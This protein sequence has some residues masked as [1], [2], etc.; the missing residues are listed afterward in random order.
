MSVRM[1][2]SNS[3]T[4]PDRAAFAPARR[5]L[6]LGLGLLL[7][8]AGLA[9]GFWLARGRTPAV[10]PDSP[11]VG[12]ARD[13]ASHHAQAVEMAVVLREN[14]DDPKM[15][16]LALDIMLTQQGQIGQIQGW[17]ALW[18]YPLA[19][20]GPAMAWMGMPTTDMMP[21]MATDEQLKQLSAAQGVAA[22]GLFLQLMIAHHQGGVAMAQAILD[23]TQH[24]VVR[25][26]AQTIVNSQQS[27]IAYMQDLLEQKG[28]PRVTET[29]GGG[30]GNMQP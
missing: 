23:R 15:R 3:T 18:G 5:L 1:D 4:T 16:Q 17:L 20:T 8:A 19:R 24:P 14:S 25:Q 13:M 9:L 22:D 10:G 30:H 11:E 27:E 29:P 7:L 26:L 21:G 2:P 6:A 28:F 12:F